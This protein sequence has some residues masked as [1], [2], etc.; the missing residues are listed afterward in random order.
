MKQRAYTL[1]ELLVVISIIAILSALLFPVFLATRAAAYQLTASSAL[2]QV[3]RS[4]IMYCGDND[5]TY[6]PA[7]Y[8]S[9][10][11]FF[12]WFGAWDSQKAQFEP[13][14]GFLSQYEGRTQLKDSVAQGKTYLGDHSGFGYNWGFIGSDFH[15]TNDFST[16]PN[17]FN[18]ATSSMLKDPS[19]TVVFAT[20]AFYFAP[21]LPGGDGGLYDFGFVDPVGYCNGDPNVD[22]RHISP[23]LVNVKAQTITFPGN[24]LVAMSDGHVKPFKIGALQDS[25]FTRTGSGDPSEL[26]TAGLP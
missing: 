11:N 26:S 8:N 18:E 2:N 15:I 12:A 19:Q 21:W 1:S 17:C 5:D 24:A 10:T 9:G 3:N 7:M 6:M 25:F 20:S 23:R 22:F 4:A 14:T 13:G 16:Y